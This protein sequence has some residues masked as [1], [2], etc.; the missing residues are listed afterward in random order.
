MLMSAGVPLPK[1]VVSHGFVNADDGRKMSKTFGNV[2]DPIAVLEKYNSDLV[3]YFCL[4]EG[5]F[6]DDFSYSDE[7]LIFRINSELADDV[8]NLVHRSFNL[9][10][11]WNEGK[12][13][14]ESYE[15]LFSVDDLKNQVDHLMSKFQIQQAFETVLN[16]VKITNKYL[17]DI[18]PWNLGD[19]QLPIKLKCVRTALEALYILA[20]FYLP[21]MP[22]S[23]ITL[24]NNFDLLPKS[25]TEIKGWGNL[26][27]GH[28]LKFDNQ[29]LYPKI[30]LNR[31]EKKQQQLQQQQQSGSNKENKDN[32]TQEK[33]NKQ[34]Q[35]SQEKNEKQL[36]HQ[37]KIP[38][39]KGKNKK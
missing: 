12:V 9:A 36:Q 20:H 23:M 15:E 39:Q 13:P 2:V 16:C 26:E 18:A 29:Q 22:N 1:Q 25:L 6:G 11:K 4:R 38:Q 8:G 10:I 24:F 14:N 5:V 27:P 33:K 35:P 7:S 37:E 19:N 34:S 17:A 30:G 32:P 28:K 21:I 31:W 3:R